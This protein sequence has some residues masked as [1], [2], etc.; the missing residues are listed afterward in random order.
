MNI[1]VDFIPKPGDRIRYPSS[2]KQ[3]T[4]I[5]VVCPGCGEGRWLVQ[6]QTNRLGFSGRCKKCAVAFAKTIGWCFINS[7]TVGLKRK[8]EA[9][10]VPASSDYYRGHYLCWDCMAD[11]H[12]F[13]KVVGGKTS[14]K[15]FLDPDVLNVYHPT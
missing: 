3:R 11:W 1:A 15:E 10:R 7:K 14:W 5:W 2:G 9:C 4:F 6:C 12:T 13:D 8:C